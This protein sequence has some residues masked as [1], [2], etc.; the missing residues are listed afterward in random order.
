MAFASAPGHHDKP[1]GG[2]A[3]KPGKLASSSLHTTRASTRPSNAP[4]K[5]LTVRKI[6]RYSHNACYAVERRYRLPAQNGGQNYDALVLSQYG[7][8]R[9]FRKSRC[10]AVLPRDHSLAAAAQLRGRTATAAAAAAASVTCLAAMSSVP[11]PGNRETGLQVAANN[12]SIVYR[13]IT[14]HVSPQ[15][16]PASGLDVGRL[17]SCVL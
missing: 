9:R 7:H 17:G 2:L 8:A 16:D 3:R 4:D 11:I 14:R 5:S 1:N 12:K 15:H 6:A 10:G 13:G